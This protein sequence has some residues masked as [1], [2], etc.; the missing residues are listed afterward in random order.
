MIEAMACGTPVIAWRCGSVPEVVQHGISGLIVDD[1]AGAV[2]AV[3]SIGGLSR[4]RVRR[5]FDERFTAQAMAKRYAHLYWQLAHA[6]R[7]HESEVA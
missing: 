3:H 6:R 7:L 4:A 1:I 5:A 2:K